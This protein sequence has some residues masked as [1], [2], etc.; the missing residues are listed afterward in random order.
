[1]RW[2]LA[3]VELRGP[4]ADEGLAIAETLRQ[5]S[6]ETA[7]LFFSPQPIS[8]AD[9][10][11]LRIYS[12][13]IIVST[14]QADQRLLRNVERFLLEVPQAAPNTKVETVTQRLAGRS[15]LVVDDD[16][17]NLFVVTAALE[18]NG[19]A[20]RSAVNG[21]QALALLAKAAVDLVITDIMMPEMDGY[22]TIAAIR[23]TPGLAN[24]PVVALT[25]KALPEDKE[26]VL[27]AGADDYFSKPVDYDV[28][29]NM[30]A[31]WCAKR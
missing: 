1:H 19:A 14:P 12:D 7:I 10:A 4:G 8:E 29:V 21:K 24:I 11:R 3:L 30:A 15:I 23:G 22:Q 6:P 13:S 2:R 25:A 31:L 5:V 28:L 18:Q 17:R 16:P 20:V 26:R 27:A 9:E